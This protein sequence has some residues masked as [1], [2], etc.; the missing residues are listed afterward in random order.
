MIERAILVIILMSSFFQNLEATIHLHASQ[1]HIIRILMEI[2]GKYYVSKI[3]KFQWDSLLYHLYFSF[4][5]HR[6]QND[7]FMDLSINIETVKICSLAVNDTE[8][9]VVE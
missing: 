4:E 5:S 2:K 6:N 1:S 7:S 8:I 9:T 3:Y